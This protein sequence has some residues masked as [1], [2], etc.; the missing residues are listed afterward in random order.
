VSEQ[1]LSIYTSNRLDLLVDVLARSIADAPLA[2]FRDE[3]VVVQSQGMARWLTLELARR[4]GIAAGLRMPFPQGFCYRLADELL[5][6]ASDSS[7][8]LRAREESDFGREI[9]IWRV[10]AEMSSWGD[11]PTFTLPYGYLV[12]D[13]DQSRRYQLARR[14]ADL[15]DNYQLYR[16]DQ[17]L[18]WEADDAAAA[19]DSPGGGHERWQAALWKKLVSGSDEENLARRFRRLI[20]GLASGRPNAELPERISVFGVATLP[21]VFVDLLAVL[22]LHVPVAV[23]FVSPTY[24]YWADLRSERELARMH[25]RLRSHGAPLDEAHFE[26]GNPLLASLGR[27]GREF[28]NLLQNADRGGSAWHAV[29][30][31]DP[32]APSD[33]DPRADDAPRALHVLQSDVLHL[34]RRGSGS[35]ESPRVA[36]GPSDRSLV[37]ASCHSPL[38]EMEVLR[39]SILAAFD[40]IEA[41]R[42]HDVLVLVTSIER[43]APYI[44]AVFGADHRDG[45]HATAPGHRGIDR[46]VRLPYSIA[47][48]PASSDDSPLRVLLELLE[49]A[50]SRVS[51]PRVLD[52]LGLDPVRRRFDLGLDDVATIARW[53]EQA[54]IRW[55]IDA[56]HRREQLG[57]PALQAN[58]WQAGLDRLLMGY[59]VGPEDSLVGGIAALGEAGGPDPA[60]LG[61]MASCLDVLFATLRSLDRPRTLDAWSIE[62]SRVLD[63]FVGESDERDERA[64]ALVARALA[65]LALGGR[66]ARLD[67]PVTLQVVRAHLRRALDEDAGAHGFIAGRITFCELKPMRTI[68]FRMICV[69]GLSED[70][71]PR[72]DRT[73]GFDLTAAPEARREGDRSLAGDDRYLFLETIL[74]ARERLVLTYEGRSER[75]NSHKAPSLVLAELLAHVDRTF[76]SADGRPASEH[77]V[78]EH[79]L[80]PF[81]RTYF[82]GTDRRLYSFAAED[83]ALAE[84]GDG[85]N[86]RQRDEQTLKRFVDA[87]IDVREEGLVAITLADLIAFWANPSRFFARSTLGVRL[88]RDSEAPSETEPFALD[89]LGAYQLAEELLGQRLAGDDAHEESTAEDLARLSARGMLPLANL[90]E[91][92]YELLDRDVSAVAA[93]IPRFHRVPPRYVELAGNGW[94]LLGAI[95]DET[96]RGLLHFRC[97]KRRPKDVVRAWIVQVVATCWASEHAEDT[98]AIT[99]PTT[100][101]VSKNGTVTLAAPA[102]PRVILDDL[103]DGFLTGR[104]RPLPFFEYASYEYARRIAASGASRTDPMS[105]A[106]G[107]YRGSSWSA[108]SGGAGPPRA[109]ASEPHVALCFRDREP[110]EEMEEEFRALAERFWSPVF[111]H[112]EGLR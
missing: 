91:P 84:R 25:S 29:E 75:D 26:Q 83:A 87:E 76:V 106:H 97:A 74:S 94:V 100:R 15:L 3:I 43:Y 36:L 20:D 78:V 21:P 55:G 63:A 56:D 48:R 38:R 60:L 51:A 19:T 41:L 67:E 52:F 107:A 79:P 22:S 35:E 10:F 90:A 81:D 80:Q 66:R 8:P 89:R 62:L 11:D 13:E 40:E 99:A 69:A 73:S 64:A 82:D 47:D 42:P 28:F 33:D 32:L 65:A 49:L 44:E 101:L 18:A 53:V 72:R 85:R 70:V 6:A 96:D 103:V 104:R 68:P 105:A 111:A 61:R 24:H 5:A 1:Q 23:Y 88:D 17:V 92:T 12:A 45:G 16:P 86:Q 50:T 77:V 2:P 93:A 98:A 27:Q 4:N 39:N 54:A 31:V 112:A 9:L 95:E 59:A 14:I 102:E 30:F 37:V 110:L 7:C 108:G 58:S 57:L 46:G 71:F 109:D 34:R